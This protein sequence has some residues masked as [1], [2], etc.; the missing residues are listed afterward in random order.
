MATNKKNIT[1]DERI[2]YASIPP[3]FYMKNNPIYSQYD[4]GDW[5]YGTPEVRHWYEG[6]KLKIGKFCSIA[7]GV[8]FLLGG[9]H[10]TE[11]VTTYPFNLLAE[12]TKGQGYPETPYT[13]GNIIIGN[14]V[15]IGTDVLIMNGVKIGDGAV[16][17]ARAVVTKDVEPYSIAGGCPARHIKYRFDEDQRRELLKIA[18]WDWPMDEITKAF[19][20]I[21]NVD[22]DSF[23]N[24]YK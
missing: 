20:L 11:W 24:R 7:E 21:M 23:I 15:W 14:D 3:E 6:A 5:T 1:N 8:L 17:A 13:K 10:H 4:I 16:I 22:I 12:E 2:D 18:W 9:G 19:S